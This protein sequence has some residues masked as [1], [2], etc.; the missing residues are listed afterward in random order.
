MGRLLRDRLEEVQAVHPFLGD[1]RGRGLMVGVEVVD[2]DRADRWGR[3]PYDGPRAR[4]VQQE[5]FRRGLILEVGG[6]HGSVLRFLPP[7][8]VTEAEVE[9][10]ADVV[11]DACGAVAAERREVARV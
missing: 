9:A 5:C 1:V 4:R 8:V 10:I 6:R 7:L 3:P 2:P 11:A